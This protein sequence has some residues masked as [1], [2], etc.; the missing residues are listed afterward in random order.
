MRICF[1]SVAIIIIFL[2]NPCFIMGFTHP[3][4]IEINQLKNT[5]YILKYLK[6]SKARPNLRPAKKTVLV[7][8]N[9]VKKQKSSYFYSMF[10]SNSFAGTFD[11]KRLQFRASR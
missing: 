5:I 2:L 3:V 4:E 9:T 10:F 1:S 8:K 6:V 7:K 11:K